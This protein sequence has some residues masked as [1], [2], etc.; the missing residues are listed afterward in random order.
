MSGSAYKHAGKT[1]FVPLLSLSG[2]ENSFEES[3]IQQVKAIH[4]TLL[5]MSCETNL[6]IK[7][8]MYLFIDVAPIFQCVPS[9]KY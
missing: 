1:C 2:L 7:K 8:K 4:Y 5:S 3:D 6:Y 9:L